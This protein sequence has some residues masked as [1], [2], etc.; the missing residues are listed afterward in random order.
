[1][2]RRD[3]HETDPL[4][5]RIGKESRID[6]LVVKRVST[7][8][9]GRGFFRDHLTTRRLVGQWTRGRVNNLVNA[10]AN[11]LAAF[12][13]RL[14]IRWPLSLVLSPSRDRTYRHPLTTRAYPD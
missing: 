4:D 2:T 11:E 1:M 8:R 14:T 13:S 9:Q 12:E 7:F 5:R 10:L 3:F 6:V